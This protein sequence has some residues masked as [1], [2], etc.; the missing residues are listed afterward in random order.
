[1]NFL[2][3]TIFKA[4]S[5]LKKHF[6]LYI[7]LFLFSIFLACCCKS[8]DYDLYA[9]L[10]V[11][12]NFFEQGVFNYTDYLSYAPT[13]TWYDHEYGASFVFYL[14]YKYF[15]AFGLVLVQ[16]LLLFF[17]SFFVIKTQQLQRHSYPTSLLFMSLFLVLLAHQNPN[18]VRCHMFSFLFFSVFLYILERA[19]HCF[20]NNK[21]TKILWIIP[22]L[23]VLW[24]NMHGGVVAGLG[25][26]FIYMICAFI[27]KQN[28]LNYLKVLI[29][30]ACLL[31]INPYG[32]EYV[33]FLF[34]ANTKSRIMISEWWDIFAPIHFSYNCPVFFIGV[35][36]FII[37]VLDYVRKKR[38]DLTK[39]AVL[40]VTLFLGIIH[41]KLLSITLITICAL[42]YDMIVRIINRKIFRI[43]ERLS[44]VAILAVMFFVP[45][46]NPAIPKTNIYKFPVKEVEFIRINNIKGNIVTEFGLGSYV[47]YKLYPDN[48]VY[49][50]GRY[51]E[52]YSDE[53]FDKLM[54]FEQ[55]KGDWLRIFREHPTD[56]LLLQKITPVYKELDNQDYWI[57]IYE[58]NKCGVFVRKDIVKNN[59]I[60]P[61]D[62]LAYYKHNE[63]VNKGYFGK[64][65][66]KNND[67]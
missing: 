65:D 53:V 10:I 46:S 42:Y 45:I 57:K 40:I 3:S 58:G 5:V 25:L 52:V 26:V 38:F 21:T 14:F 32:P 33:K 62:D 18:I 29:I 8:Y 27:L 56:I 2:E 66:G 64:R 1:M 54:D 20:T 22:P 13:H 50:D 39:F 6:F 4:V 30:S 36:T 37:S 61:I 31:I 24:N 23:I 7:L 49:M 67:R 11:G 15:G 9:R 28:W 55:K 51:E 47:S 48:L 35:F 41:I 19:R 59:Y 34:S 17:T 44:Y 12:E 43:F 16:G 60:E 63:F